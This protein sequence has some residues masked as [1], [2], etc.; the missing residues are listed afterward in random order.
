MTQKVNG[1]ISWKYF[2]TSHEKCV[3]DGIGGHAKSILPSQ[4]RLQY[5]Q[6]CVK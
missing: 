6:F 4:D 1:T 3:V 5:L 2:A